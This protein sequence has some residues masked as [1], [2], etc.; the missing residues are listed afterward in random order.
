VNSSKLYYKVTV[1]AIESAIFMHYV[2]AH[3]CGEVI[4]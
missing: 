4:L 2:T 1:R 3:Y